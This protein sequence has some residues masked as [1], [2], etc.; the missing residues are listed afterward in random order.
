VDRESFESV[1]RWKKKVEY[2]CGFISM[3]LVQNKIDLYNRSIVSRDEVDK[4]AFAYK[5]KVFQ[6]SV[7]D[8]FN[9]DNGECLL[10][11]RM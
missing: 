11:N 1:K 4:F 5:I 6:T 2:E 10:S 9:V 3:A 7:K 8:N